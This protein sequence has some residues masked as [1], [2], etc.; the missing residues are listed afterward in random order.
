MTAPHDP[1][2]ERAIL[3]AILLH[4]AT[5]ARAVD[6]GITPG[7]L[8]LDQHRRV[9]RAFVQLDRAG[10]PIDALTLAAHLGDE[11]DEIGGLSWLAGLAGA[12]PS[13]AHVGGYVQLVLDHAT[14][15]SALQLAEDIA[16]KVHGGGDVGEV[17]SLAEAGA[18]R[19]DEHTVASGFASAPDVVRS[20]LAEMRER[21]E[22]DGE[23]VGVGT[24]LR[25]LD[26]ILGGLRGGDLVIVAA[27]PS[28]GKTALALHIA[29]S[30]TVWQ[31]GRCALFSLEMPQERL[32]DRILAAEARIS[33]GRIKRGRLFAEEY[34]SLQA[35]ADRINASGLL[36]ADEPAQ[37]ITSV[38]ARTRRLHRQDPIDLLVVDYLQLLSG[39]G[40]EGSREQV[41][42]GNAR[43]LKLLAMEL[44]IPVVALSQLNRGCEA[45][46]D[47]RPLMSDLR[48]SGAIEQDADTIV[49]L[50]RDEVYNPDTEDRGI[51]ELLIR[52][53]RNGAIGEVRCAWRSE[54][55]RF[56]SLAAG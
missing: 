39:T 25:E 55:Q 5:L 16:R 10:S 7:A 13:I 52:K 40:R 17:V 3:G 44:G 56:D 41:I 49:F 35:A 46:S 22:H 54:F 27:R 45:R 30:L 38:R 47:K 1:A 29:R 8:Y 50:Y 31:A 19:L 26:Q 48:E 15:R 43:G 12:T 51:C 53:Q 6:G 14:R 23:F 20:T 2:A 32:M 18:A 24:G 28:M 21:G 11:V 36:I 9:F 37:S 34:Q 42:A 4:P 33:I